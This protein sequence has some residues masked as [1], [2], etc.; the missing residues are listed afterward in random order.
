MT[1]VACK[2]VGLMQVL[3]P[4]FAAL[5][6]TT[7]SRYCTDDSVHNRSS[8]ATK[9]H[10]DDSK[11]DTAV[12]LGLLCVNQANDVLCRNCCNAT[13]TDTKTRKGLNLGLT[14]QRNPKRTIR[15]QYCTEADDTTR[16]YS[17]VYTVS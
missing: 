12:V 5:A 6:S 15:L 16:Q 8:G 17:Y 7:S 3:P 10:V 9:R 13:D 1:R 11:E 4:R 14:R 2:Y